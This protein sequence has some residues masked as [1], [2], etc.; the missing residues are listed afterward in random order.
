M[1]KFSFVLLVLGIASFG[2]SRQSDSAAV[3]GKSTTQGADTAAHAA[4]DVVPGS[5]ED[6][7]LE[8]AVPESVCTR[9]DP[10]LA[11]AFKATNDW[12]AEHG[13]PESQCLRCNPELSIVR[14]P[15]P[16]GT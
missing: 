16:E 3:A 8:H 15:K 9:C 11:A 7:C 4:S 5:Y 13:L 14:P 12:C 10:T 6:W 2:C 1:T